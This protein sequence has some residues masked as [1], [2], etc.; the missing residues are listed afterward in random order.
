AT[1]PR[2]KFATA[3]TLG[4]RCAGSDS[5]FVAAPWMAASSSEISST[6]S[7]TFGAPSLIASSASTRGVIGSKSTS[8]NA[9]ASAA[10]ASLAATTAAT[11]WPAYKTRSTASGLSCPAALD[12]RS[13]PVNTRK[14]HGDSAAALVSMDLIQ[15]AG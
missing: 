15:V 1:S 2:L 6:T 9:A 8:T 11:G 7:R 10:E 4:G 5:D 13:A 12:S 14:T 3:V